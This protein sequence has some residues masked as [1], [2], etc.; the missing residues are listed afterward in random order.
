MSSNNQPSAEGVMVIM[1]LMAFCVAIYFLLV[2]AFI[3]LFLASVVYTLVALWAWEKPRRFLGE[4]VTPE[5]AQGFVVRGFIGAFAFCVVAMLFCEFTDIY[6]TEDMLGIVGI[7]GYAAGAI[8]VG[9]LIEEQKK[10]TTVQEILPPA[11]YPPPLPP[12][13]PAPPKPFS[14]AEWEDGAGQ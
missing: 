9:V 14:F 10:Q 1:V 13:P 11:N 8:G 4:T 6:L 7:L 12:V 5:E 3:L 2:I